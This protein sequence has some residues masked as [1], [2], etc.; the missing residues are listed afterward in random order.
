MVRALAESLR[1]LTNSTDTNPPN[2][3][4]HLVKYYVDSGFRIPPSTPEHNEREKP[5]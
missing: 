4:V 2:V 1:R 5:F 3:D